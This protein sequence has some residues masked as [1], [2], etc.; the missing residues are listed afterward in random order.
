MI[1]FFHLARKWPKLMKAW[2]E[3]EK[4]LPVSNK[5]FA[6]QALGM[7]VKLLSFTIIFL[8]L[9][10]A[11]HEALSHSMPVTNLL[12]K[13]S[14]KVFFRKLVFSQKRVKFKKLKNIKT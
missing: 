10:R 8:S 9:S 3:I 1:Y 7:K 4:N 11:K 13:V 14:Y 6:K 2:D 12:G 5:K